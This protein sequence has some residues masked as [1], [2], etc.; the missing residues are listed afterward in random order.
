MEG[1]MKAVS[2]TLSRRLVLKGLVAAP[3][4]MA[5]PGPVFGQAEAGDVHLVSI[6]DLHS[7]YRHLARLLTVIREAKATAPNVPLAVLI[8]GDV[9]ERGNAVALRSEGAA[10]WAFLEALVAEAPVVLNLRNHETALI[11]DMTEFVGRASDTG[12]EVIGNLVDVRTGRFFAPVSTR[13]ELGGLTLGLLG[14]AP[15]NPFVYREPIRETLGFLE[16]VSFVRQNRQGL[17]GEAD[18]PV[19]MSHAGVVPDRAILSDLGEEPALVI[20]GHDHLRLDHEQGAARYFHGG[21]WGGE[22]RLVRVH[23]GGT[24]FSVETIPVEASVAPDEA[25][26]AIID[27]QLESHLS[28]EDREVIAMRE[29]ALDLPSSILVAVEAVRRAADADIAMLG[30]TTFGQPLLAG[31]LTAYDFDAFVRFDGDIR[32]AEISGERLSRIMALANQHDAAL[33]DERTGDFVH[34][35]ELDI[36]PDARYR[37]AVNGWTAMNQKAYLGTDDLEF[38][39]VENLALKAI[40]RRALAEGA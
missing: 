24:G 32:I 7:P 25:L 27:E 13:L 35:S 26:Q 17:L 4:A 14:L 15:T 8:N 37:L 11:D 18:I 33:L 21:S 6:A 2:T 28:E 30:H 9:F 19:L 10:D 1:L 16:P 38:A 12:I 34:A 31:P 23:G 22:V 36:D 5:V 20:G 29:T 3:A 39:E 40:V